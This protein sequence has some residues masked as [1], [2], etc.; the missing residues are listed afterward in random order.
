MTMTRSSPLTDCPSSASPTSGQ[1]SLNLTFTTVQT[2]SH[3]P[4]PPPALQDYDKIE[5]SDRLSTTSLTNLR[6]GIFQP[7]RH[8]N[9]HFPYSP[10]PPPALQDYDKIEPS[11]RLSIIGLTN[12][13][14]GVPL[15][16]EGRRTDGSTYSFEVRTDRLETGARQA[17]G[18]WDVQRAQPTP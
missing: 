9:S 10:T 14:P 3:F 2:F 15:T 11:D 6:P 16:V 8:H 13:R 7:N 5:P 12:L 1:A 17:G 18:M 4:T